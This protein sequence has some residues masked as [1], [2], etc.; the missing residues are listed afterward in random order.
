MAEFIPCLSQTK[1]NMKRSKFHLFASLVFIWLLFSNCQ[2]S[3]ALPANVVESIEKRIENEL[4]PSIA[5][6]IVD[7]NGTKFYNFG[8]VSVSGKLVDEHT[9]YEIGSI[10]KVFTSILLSQKVIEGSV[11]LDD[12]INQF[13]PKDI[14]VPVMGS[15]EITLGNL[16][17]HTSGLPRLPQNM[18]PENP[19]NPYAD[20]SVDQMYSFISTYKP[21]REVGAE[22]E[23]SN[24]A[25]GLLGHI[26]ALNGGVSYESLMIDN[27]AWPLG[28]KETKIALDQKMSDNLA[29]GHSGG[30]EVE[31][32]DLPTLAGAGAIRSSTADMIKFVAANLG[33]TQSSLLPSMQLSHTIRHNK[34]GE[35][36]VGL[37]W[38]VKQGAEG[39]VVWHN[40][41]TG[42]YKSFAGFVKETGK[43][44]VI[45]TNSTES[46]DDI[47]M[48]LLDSDS[49]LKKVK[50]KEDAV[51]VPEK[52]LE[53]YVGTYELSP[54]F[55]IVITREGTRLFEQATGQGKLEVFAKNDTD[56]FLKVVDAQ[57]TFQV[58]EDETVESMTLFQNGQ[59]MI[60]KR[61][62]EGA[63]SEAPSMPEV[64]PVAEEILER[65]VGSY[66][67]AT[68]FS[69]TITREG[70]QLFE[71]ATGQGRLKIFAKS[72]TE[73]F[74]TAV[75]A[76]AT[77][78]MKDDGTVESMT[79]FQNGQQI[80]GKKTK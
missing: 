60:G 36:R 41:G 55:R 44:V 79:W 31:N 70:T 29:T 24:L 34:A 68:S 35:M 66:Q 62:E 7:E 47:G 74:M 53:R 46:V 8:K 12:P 45:L 5:I 9:I 57:I 48:H 54:A 30:A 72:E 71:Q 77:F 67:L 27:I 38:H 6:A 15:R 75:D 4:N 56:F 40:G 10:S 43:G 14:A 63:V 52:V 49:E 80:V 33:L 51:Q 3:A 32:W 78:Q 76:Q 39:D 58:R 1:K 26:L 50:P 61:L 20:Y 21:I 22:Y 23:Y 28:M 42:G 59:K 37:A 65:Y 18:L 25:Q 69:I 17:D 19:N 16:S 64:V 13:L 11:S 73:F 2:P